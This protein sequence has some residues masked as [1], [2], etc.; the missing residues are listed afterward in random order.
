MTKSSKTA[1]EIAPG[2]EKIVFSKDDR[3]GNLHYIAINLEDDDYLVLKIELDGHIFLNHSIDDI[4]TTG[5]GKLGLEV[6]KAASGFLNVV[7]DAALNAV[8]VINAQGDD[9]IW[10]RKV[11]ITVKNRGSAA[12][13]IQAFYIVYHEIYRK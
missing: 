12:F 3:E 10:R 4:A 6:S 8:I 9:L 11:R 7:R 5:A 13:D 1:I 2:T